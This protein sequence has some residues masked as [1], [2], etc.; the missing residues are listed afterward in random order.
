MLVYGYARYSSERQTENSIEQQKEEILKYCERNNYNLVKFYSDSAIS[1]KRDDREQF[2][3][4]IND[5]IKNKNV[6]A[7][8]VWKLDRFARNRY[9]SAVY[10]KRLREVGI[11]V[12]SITQKIDN[13]PES[14]ILEG[15]LESIDE[16]YCANLA[17]NVKRKLYQNAQECKFNGGI[18][19]LGYDIDKDTKKYIIN[20]NEA[21]IVREMFDLY[22]KGKSLIEITD[23]FN[24]KGY[25]TKRGTDFK[26]NSLYDMI[27]NERYAGYYIYS[28]SLNHN[29]RVNRDDIIKIEDG[30]P[31]I[32]SKERMKKIME[33]RE[34]NKKGSFNN[35]ENYYLTGLLF[36]ETG[37]KYVGTRR[38]SKKKNGKEYIN[39]YYVSK[40]SNIRK[41]IDK[42]KL[43]AAVF[44]LIKNTILNEDYISKILIKL[45]EY[46]NNK[47]D[48][49]QE[50]INNM[51]K[52]LKEI[53]LKISN[54]MTLIEDGKFVDSMFENLKKLEERKK[55]L[56][57]ELEKLSTRKQKGRY[58]IKELKAILTNDIKKWSKVSDDDKKAFFARY[59]KEIRVIDKDTLSITLTILQQKSLLNLAPCVGL[60]PTTLRLTAECSTT[61]LTRNIKKL[62]TPYFPKD[63]T[64]KYLLHLRA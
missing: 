32:I 12:I 11:R 13:S 52:E 6:E 44:K 47:K 31:A 59:I 2:Q 25:K 33:Q 28:K 23:I 61:E 19:P 36:D 64:L 42:D 51:S 20:E 24:S 57:S 4:M 30:I 58:E 45:N 55:D 26:K 53:E 54:F 1:G 17:A 62:A 41:S 27:G 43:E 46:Y 39:K 40:N 48:D 50:D 49:I 3:L 56:T 5:C 7:I 22:E 15:M 8:L 38:K 37:N 63:F 21:K 60:E 34:K 35:K 18:P 10:K 9:D 16:Y 29:K 14:I